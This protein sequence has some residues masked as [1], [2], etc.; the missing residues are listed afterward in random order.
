MHREIY[1]TQ[2]RPTITRLVAEVHSRCAQAKVPLPDR[3][4]VV[5]RVRAIP[6]RLRAVRRGD[7]NALKAVTATPGELVARR[8]LEIVQIDHTQVDVTVVDEE[9]RQPLPGRPWLTLRS[10]S[11]R[12]W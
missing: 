3:R 6:E 4:T 5:A 9:H 10:I 1:L 2:N 12:G 7:G 11:S 8:P